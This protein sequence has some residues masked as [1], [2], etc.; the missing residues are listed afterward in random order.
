[1]HVLATLCVILLLYTIDIDECLEGQDRCVQL[2][3]NTI[4]SYRCNCR[5]GY[6]IDVDG[7]SCD[8]KSCITMMPAV[9]E[10]RSTPLYHQQT[11]VQTSMSATMVLI[12]VSKCVITLVDPI[13]AHVVMAIN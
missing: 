9:G 3:Q 5:S 10:I 4:G 2:C 6:I 11:Y 8:G 12:L 1:M 7:T 13:A